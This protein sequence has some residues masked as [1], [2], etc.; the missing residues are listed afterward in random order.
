[1]LGALN[2]IA[3]FEYTQS[4]DFLRSV[5]FPFARDA[6]AF[7][8]CWMERRPDGSW[9]NTRDQS[10]ECNPTAPVTEAKKRLWCY[11]NNSGV[12]NGFIRRVASALPLMAAALGEP[13]DPAWVEIRDKLDPLPTA[14]TAAGTHVYTM[15]GACARTHKASPSF[16]P[17]RSFLDSASDLSDRC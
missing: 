11:Q 2:M 1:M 7:Y 14:P 16:L 6:L 12:S 9:V 5:A 10:H 13:V 4:S 17:A 15:A 8:Q 3:H